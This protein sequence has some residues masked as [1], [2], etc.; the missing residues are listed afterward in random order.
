M[1]VLALA[2]GCGTDPAAP[3][4]RARPGRGNPA[5]GCRNMPE[6]PEFRSGS[7]CCPTSGAQCYPPAS[8]PLEKGFIRFQRGEP[9]EALCV[10]GAGRAWS[11]QAGPSRPHPA[12]NRALPF[13]AGALGFFPGR[14][15][16]ECELTPRSLPAKA[17]ARRGGPASC[18]LDSP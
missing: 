3:G 4:D 6:N 18:A 12:R 7:L 10:R 15:C 9:L 5:L 1:R 11:P 2:A 17:A 13:S 8:L 16:V 14:N